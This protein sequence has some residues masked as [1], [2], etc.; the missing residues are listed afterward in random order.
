MYNR[1][2]EALAYPSVVRLI[3]STTIGLGPEID[4]G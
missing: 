3:G 1:I 4:E 2:E